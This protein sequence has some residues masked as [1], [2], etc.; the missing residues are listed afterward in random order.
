MESLITSRSNPII[1]NTVLLQEAKHRAQQGLFIAEGLRTCSTL[2]QNGL[3]CVT[4]FVTPATEHQISTL[5]NA[6]QKIL[7]APDVMGKIST[8]SSPSGILGVFKIPTNPTGPLAVPGLVLADVN[9]PGNMGAL[10]RT[11]AAVNVRTVVIVESCDP[12]NSKVIQ[13]S[14]GT[15]GMMRIIRWTWEELIAHK[16]S[17]PLYALVVENGTPIQNVN[18]QNGLLVIGNEAHGIPSA[19]LTDCEQLVTIPMPGNTESLNAAV[20]GSIALYMGNVK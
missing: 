14:A 8:A 4:L 3:E 15:I 19:L 5:A 6:R 10:I 12:W 13:A 17:I 16:G 2:M 1:K 18:T 7:V 9:D 11:A 20:A